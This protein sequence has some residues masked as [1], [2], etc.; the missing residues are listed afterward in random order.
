MRATDAARK[1]GNSTHADARSI[2]PS[3]LDRE[4]T[5]CPDLM[6]KPLDQ[7]RPTLRASVAAVPQDTGSP[8]ASDASPSRL[9][10]AVLAA[11]GRLSRSVG[12]MHF[13]TASEADRALRPM[14]PTSAWDPWP[15]CVVRESCHAAVP[16]LCC[17]DCPRCVWPRRRTEQTNLAV[18][19]RYLSVY[20][21]VAAMQTCVLTSKILVQKSPSSRLNPGASYQVNQDGGKIDVAV[22]T[23]I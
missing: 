22:V 7:P 15:F 23:F 10:P 18:M 11:C 8:R 3:G 17:H 14:L 4:D 1:N 19:L 16:G 12:L 20:F 13:I 9:V 6:T 21:V 5:G 2:G